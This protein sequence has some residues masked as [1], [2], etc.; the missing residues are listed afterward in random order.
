MRIIR[1]LVRQAS[2]DAGLAHVQP[3]ENHTSAYLDCVEVPHEEAALRA[4]VRDQRWSDSETVDNDTFAVFRAGTT[5]HWG[6]GVVVGA[7]TNAVGKAPNGRMARFVAIGALS[8]DFGGGYDLSQR[9][10][11]HAARDEDGRGAPTALRQA[12]LERFGMSSVHEVI[13]AFH[14]GTLRRADQLALT[15]LLFQIAAGGDAIAADLV[16]RQAHEVALLAKSVMRRLDLMSTPT[17]VVLGGGV[18]TARDPLLMRRIEHWM[19]REVPAALTRVNDVPAIAGAAL[20]GLDHLGL[21][22]PSATG[23]RGGTGATGADAEQRLRNA[24]GAVPMTQL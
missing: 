10:M 16:D 18:L 12:V 8:G 7:G 22:G 15:P 17:D 11:W 6:V 14:L 23:G 24:F 21:S 20:L 9:V 13:V 4:A 5:T 3:L 19:A 1:S 2:L